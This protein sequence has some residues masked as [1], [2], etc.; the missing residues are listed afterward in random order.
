M[1]DVGAKVDKGV[2][3]LVTLAIT[4][5]VLIIVGIIL[6]MLFDGQSK[7]GSYAKTIDSYDYIGYDDKYVS[8]DSVISAIKNAKNPSPNKLTVTVTT[9][10]GSSTSYG[11]DDEADTTYA[12]YSESDPGDTDFI[13]PNGTFKAS[14]V[15]N[16]DVV[17]GIRF[18]QE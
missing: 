13:N 9:L 7:L 10:A 17:T 3:L 6:N 16:N 5:V 14:L 2:G 15:K 12:G 8:G 18:Q 11:Y 1:A 4:G